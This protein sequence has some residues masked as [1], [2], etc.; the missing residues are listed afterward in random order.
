M[1]KLTQ[2]ISIWSSRYGLAW[3]IR[4]C[5]ALKMTTHSVPSVCAIVVALAL[6]D[7]SFY[8]PARSR[9]GEGVLVFLTYF[10]FLSCNGD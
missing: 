4:R 10:V 5:N 7:I 6:P 9:E 2:G 8:D 1:A 3:P